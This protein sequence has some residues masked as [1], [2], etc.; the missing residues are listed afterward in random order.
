MESVRLEDSDTNSR[1]LEEL[2]RK[3]KYRIKDRYRL[4]NYRRGN[5]IGWDKL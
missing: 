1:D 2:V 3:Y 5:S 4:E